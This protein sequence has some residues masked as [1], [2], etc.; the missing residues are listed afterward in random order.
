MNEFR[1]HVKEGLSKSPKKLSSRYFYDERGDALF[2]RIMK[3]EEYY[4]PA[5]EM[6]IIRHKSEQIAGMIA[7]IHPRLQI[8][9]LGAGDGSK[10]K[11]LLH[12]FAS[13]FTK[14]E[15]VAMDI[16]ENILEI[17]KKAVE[18]YVPAIQQQS[19]PGNYLQ[20]YTT[21]PLTEK[22]RLVL[23]L[24]ANIGNFLV[25]EAIH[26]FNF[27]KQG[28]RADDFFLVAFDLVK[29][30]RK[31]IKAYDDSQGVTKAFNL[32][33]L[34]RMNRE[35]GADFNSALFDHFPYYNPLNGITSS[36]LISLTEQQVHFADGFSVHFEA[37]EAIHTEVSK[38]FFITDI[39][40]IAE[41]S[42]MQLV[43]TF[44][45]ADKEYAFVLFRPGP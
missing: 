5:C 39:E 22:G 42:G 6:N 26:F 3:L 2:Q 33:L 24:G 21:L 7:R 31:I 15:Y 29:H 13:Q 43:E 45:D 41:R 11:F 30:P 18:G 35:L 37:F 14:V 36:Q 19:L 12:R 17:N 34:D 10:T 28:L 38:K 8:V 40:T 9:E 16:S 27:I 23:F 1:N 4:L 20:T 32:N 44:F 25:E